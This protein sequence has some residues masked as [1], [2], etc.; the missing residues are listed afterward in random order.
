MDTLILILDHSHLYLKRYRV[1]EIIVI[2][3]FLYLAWNQWE[4]YKSNQ[5]EMLE[6]SLAGFISMNAATIG[7]LKYALDSINK[8]HEKDD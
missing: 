6:W 3:F 7:A 8:R 4:Y 2:A 5:S 1:V